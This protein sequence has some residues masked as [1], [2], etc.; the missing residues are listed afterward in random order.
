MIDGL[1]VAFFGAE[2][3]RSL[4]ANVII[5]ITG[6]SYTGRSTGH[7]SGDE[8]SFYPTPNLRTGNL[9]IFLQLNFKTPRPR[10]QSKTQLFMIENPNLSVPPGTFTCD[11]GEQTS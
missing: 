7:S 6:C 3:G 4:S 2:R 11:N 9:S 1:K 8:N 10:S 5:W